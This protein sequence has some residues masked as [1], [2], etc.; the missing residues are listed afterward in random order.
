MVHRVSQSCVDQ[1]VAHLLV[2]WYMVTL[3]LQQSMLGCM[4]LYRCDSH[5]MVKHTV[6]CVPVR[7]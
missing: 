2:A 1:R 3:T 4:Q 6:G 7:Y 5:V